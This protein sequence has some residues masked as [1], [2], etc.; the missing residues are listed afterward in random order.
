MIQSSKHSASSFHILLLVYLFSAFL[1]GCN[2]RPEVVIEGGIDPLFKVSGR[3]KIHVITISGP[4]FDNPN[5]RDPGSRYMKPFWQIVANSG[6]DIA[7]LERSGGIA[8][9][10]VPDGF[11]Q[12]FPQSGA[13]P[14]PLVENELFTFDLRLADGQAV[15]MRFVIRKGKVAVEGS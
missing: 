15:G 1:A 11:K 10:E 5:S 4:D 12:V 3:G 14:Q 9:G 13:A 6:H 7:L 8:Y 2:H